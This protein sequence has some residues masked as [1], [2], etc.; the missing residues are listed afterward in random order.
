MG[1]SNE[2]PCLGGQHPGGV[3]DLWLVTTEPPD[4]RY[5]T[6]KCI[7]SLDNHIPVM[8]LSTSGRASRLP[9]SPPP[10]GT[11]IAL[12]M[13]IACY[14][15]SPERT[16]SG[17]LSSKGQ[18]KSTWKTR[19]KLYIWT[20]RPHVATDNP[21]SVAGHC[22]ENAAVYYSKGY[23]LRSGRTAVLYCLRSTLRAGLSFLL[24]SSSG[25]GPW[26]VPGTNHCIPF[27]QGLPATA[28]CHL[29]EH[30]HGLHGSDLRWLGTPDWTGEC[31]D[32]HTK[33]VV[34]SK[35]AGR[36][37]RSNHFTW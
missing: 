5:V 10:S 26:P 33:T 17:D 25:M 11:C 30:F 35:Q 4:C 29:P 12:L 1:W 27:L 6:A 36:Q 15:T 2:S 9:R 14:S 31:P 34:C 16:E 32:R 22:E 21:A 13:C 37:P 24:S 28:V 19:Q 20:V 23:V 7:L 8:R 3:L 18:S